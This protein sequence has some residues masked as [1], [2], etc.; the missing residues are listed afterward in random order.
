MT[1]LSAEDRAETSATTDAATPGSRLVYAAPVH[2]LSLVIADLAW[3][4]IQGAIKSV[5]L[6]VA[7]RGDDSLAVENT[8]SG[9]PDVPSEIWDVVKEHAE[10]D[11]YK[12]EEDSFFKQMRKMQIQLVVRA[13][14]DA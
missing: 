8:A 12:A 5:D 1:D 6:I 10:E 13:G 3:S 9:L 4:R 2:T 14:K 11:L 7:R